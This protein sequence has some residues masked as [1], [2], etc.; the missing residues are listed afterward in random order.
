MLSDNLT[1]IKDTLEKFD[2]IGIDEGQFFEDIVNISGELADSGKIVVVAALD[3]TFERKPFGNVASLMPLAEQVDKLTAI[4]IFCRK[5]ASFTL[6][7]VNS[8][9]LELME[10]DAYSPACRSCYF[11]QRK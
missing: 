6:R 10:T 7:T 2:V 11:N 5:E 4:C 3:A 8:Q 1:S 9:E